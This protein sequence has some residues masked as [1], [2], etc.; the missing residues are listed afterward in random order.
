MKLP[1]NVN[2]AKPGRGVPDVAG[3]ADITSGYIVLVDGTYSP[4]GGT[5]AVAP[6]YAG[7]TAL[8]AQAL[9]HPI[10]DVLPTLYAAPGAVF[11]DVVEGDNSVPQSQYG[12]KVAGYSAAPGWDACTGLGSIRGDALLA[13]LRSSPAAAA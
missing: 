5:S 3:N 7:L 4:V 2:G 9:G 13:E 8:L 10:G 6:L 1:T 11:R 12:P